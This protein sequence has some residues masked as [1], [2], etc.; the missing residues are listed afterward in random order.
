MK[1]HHLKIVIFIRLCM[2]TGQAGLSSSFATPNLIISQFSKWVCFAILCCMTLRIGPL[3]S[4]FQW[5]IYA[6]VIWTPHPTRAWCGKSGDNHFIFTSLSFPGGQ[7]EYLLHSIGQGMSGAFIFGLSAV[8]FSRHLV[9]WTFDINYLSSSC[10]H[11]VF[12][13]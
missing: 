11:V 13:L 6:P 5:Y 4:P 7:G 2:I 3:T 10:G 8:A 12:T 9:I 1:C